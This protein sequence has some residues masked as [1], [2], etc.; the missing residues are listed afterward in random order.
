MLFPLFLII[1]LY[2]LIP[3]VIAEIINP[4]AELAIL[5]GTPTN[6]ANIENETQLLTTETKTRIC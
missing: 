1:D 3:F 5:T 4:T 6:E 2:F